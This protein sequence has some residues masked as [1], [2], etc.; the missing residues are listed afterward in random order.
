M[1]KRTIEKTVS[2]P[3]YA[4]I[5]ARW[6]LRVAAATPSGSYYPLITAKV[7]TA[8][9]F[10]GAIDYLGGTLCPNWNASSSVPS[11]A[12]ARQPLDDRHKAVRRLL[13]LDN[14]TKE[15]A[16]I[17]ALTGRIFRFRDSFAH[18]KV[19]EKTIQDS[20]SNELAAAPDI[21][22]EAEVDATLIQSDFDTI[23]AYSVG[24]L[25]TAADCLESVLE[26]GWDEWQQKYP[27]LTDLHLEAAY[28]RGILHSPSH[29]SAD[30]NP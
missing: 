18:P 5:T 30:Y 25:D 13:D 16:D 20:V 28:L 4:R 27:H 14:G 23:E 8:F 3:A 26:R 11:R 12:P 9:M 15:Y 6:A 2:T 22:W 1:L 19:L 10:E 7:F 29:S 17:R 21:A 24:L